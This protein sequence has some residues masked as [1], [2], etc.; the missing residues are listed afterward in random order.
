MKYVFDIDGTLTPSRLPIDPE[1][2]KFFLEWMEGKEVYLVTGSD[3]DKTMEQVGEKIWTNATK[4]YQSCGNAVYENG[5]LIRQIDFELGKDLKKL[6]E[7]FLQVS[8][9]TDRFDNHIEKRIGLINFSTIGRS[10]TQEARERYA[11]WDKK[12]EERLLFCKLIEDRYPHLEAT[13]GGQISIDIYP[14]GKNKGQVLSEL[15]GPISFFGDRCEPGGNDYPIV[16]ILDR[17][18]LTMK[19]MSVVFDVN[20]WEDTWNYLK[21][22]K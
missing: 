15:E 3:K 5:E 2:E 10:C 4:V 13:V 14:K 9:W 20:G 7:Q 16:E 8:E 6:L 11:E 17:E 12:I 22:I 21:N 19:R 18:R 1:F